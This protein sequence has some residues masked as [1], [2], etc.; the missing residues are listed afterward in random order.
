MISAD[1]ELLVHLYTGRP[2]VPYLS[3]LPKERVAP[4]TP[5]EQ[6]AGLRDILAAYPVRWVVTGS[7]DGSK[8]ARTI[9][10]ARPD[11]LLFRGA[12]STALIFEGFP[13]RATS[14]APQ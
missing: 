5:A 4:Q 2:T 11:R 1:F 14:G 6:E 3:F 12:T 7:L 8:A 10:A 9:A 13:R